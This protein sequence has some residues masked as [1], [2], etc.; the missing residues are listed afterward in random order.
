MPTIY[1]AQPESNAD[2]AQESSAMA[3][4]WG[5]IAQWASV[6]GLECVRDAFSGSA[7]RPWDADDA[8]LL[9]AKICPAKND[10][11]AGAIRYAEGDTENFALARQLAAYLQEFC[12]NFVQIAPL[13]GLPSTAGKPAILQLEIWGRQPWFA[14]QILCIAKALLQ[15]VHT[16]FLQRQAAARREWTATV[17]SPCDMQVVYKNPTK[18]AQVIAR[19]RNG[20][21]VLVRRQL[22]EWLCIAC[23]K[24]EGYVQKQFVT[25]EYPSAP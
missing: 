17:E 9:Q 24:T 14:E 18:D 13:Q 22:Q 11:Y 1:L 8:V 10:A 20:E 19:L 16:Y 23:G 12:V 2:F 3:Q 15:A 7:D 21:R 6:A 5:M 25:L 4:L